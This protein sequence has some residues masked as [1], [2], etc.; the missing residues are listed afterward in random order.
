MSSYEELLAQQAAQIESEFEEEIQIEE[1][2]NKRLDSLYKQCEAITGKPVI[3][4]WYFKSGKLQGLV[5]HIIQNP[6]KRSELLGIT[7]LTETI[8]RKFDA[9]AGRLPYIDKKTNSIVEGQ[10]PDIQKFKKLLLYIAT[11]LG[12]II[13]NEQ[14]EDLTEENWEKIY[15]R[16]FESIT[17]TIE[18][19]N[20]FGTLIKYDE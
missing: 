18:A 1:I 15:E 3:E 19:D 7:G 10:L 16:R 14:L 8:L 6:K 20:K 4:D 12:I 9:V 13:S 11:K 17:K 2:S 5:R